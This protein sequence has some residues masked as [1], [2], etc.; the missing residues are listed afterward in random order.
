MNSSEDYLRVE[1]EVSGEGMSVCLRL[2]GE[3]DADTVHLVEDAMSPALDR[4][5]TRLV[6]DLADVSFMD[7]SGLR[8]LVVARNALDDRGAEMVIAGDNDQ[9]RRLFEISGLASVFAFEP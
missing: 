3:V 6:V 8:V 4:R 9:L 2:D 1:C 7:S 5:C